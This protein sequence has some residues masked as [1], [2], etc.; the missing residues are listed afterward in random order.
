MV[1]ENVKPDGS[2][3]QKLSRIGWALFFIW[4]GFTFLL[5]FGAGI[6]LLGVGVITLGIQY[7]R[8]S[9]NLPMEGF[10]VV[11]GV[12]FL[13]GGIS[14]LLDIDLPL[15]PILLIIAGVVILLSIRKGGSSSG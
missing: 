7:A 2:L 3:S 8:K 11:V 13:L 9:A 15:I 4:I 14:G 10:W 5:N 6:G 1:D 12:L